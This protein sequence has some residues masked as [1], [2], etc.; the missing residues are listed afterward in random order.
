MTGASG[1]VRA[2]VLG[3]ACL[4]AAAAGC[5]DDAISEG[6]GYVML[7]R[8]ARLS[9]A[10]LRVDGRAVSDLLPERVGPGSSVRVVTPGGELSVDV[11][12]GE[13]AVLRG[14]DAHVTPFVL[15]AEAST[16]R[17][18]VAATREAAEELA[19]VLGAELT[20]RD[21][22]R[23]ELFSPGLFG[24]A[25]GADAYMEVDDVLP[26]IV[27]AALAA[28][29]GLP[30]PAL[31]GDGSGSDASAY[32]AGDAL[33]LAAAFMQGRGE[34]LGGGSDPA[35]AHAG[36]PAA[37]VAAMRLPEPSLPLLVGVYRRGGQTLVIDAEG[38][39]EIHPDPD[40][41][42]SGD[43][44]VWGWEPSE[45]ELPPPTSAGRVST[46]RPGS[47][48]AVTLVPRSGAPMVIEA[49]ADG[50]LR[51]DGHGY[52]RHSGGGT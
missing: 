25:G 7:D 28:G 29:V 33:R 14:R 9:G 16:E 2:G 18:V 11:G 34:G 50:A 5:A 41:R 15:G 45:A 1:A 47:G 12:A 36:G 27:D 19:D 30:A 21:D 22:G 38:G 44:P 51:V 23:Y 3:L 52:A 32:A 24:V 46:A 10:R 35:G 49:F 43:V 31:L 37:N 42:V 20:E 6:D 26:V 8:D 17:L 39:F 4:A 40:L 13:L 48:G